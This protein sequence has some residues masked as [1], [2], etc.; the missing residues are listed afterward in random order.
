MQDDSHIAVVAVLPQCDA[1]PVAG[2]GRS[3]R[4]VAVRIELR[5]A[6]GVEAG[7][8][9]VVAQTGED[10]GVIGGADDLHGAAD[11]IGDV[12]RDSIDG[13]SGA[14]PEELDDQ[15]RAGAALQS[16]RAKGVLIDDVVNRAGD[17]MDNVGVIPDGLR[18][19]FLGAN[20]HA[21]HGVARFGVARNQRPAVLIVYGNRVERP[22]AVA[23]IGDD[24]IIQRVG[25]D[26]DDVSLIVQELVV[27]NHWLGAAN[28]NRRPII[29]QKAVAISRCRTAGIVLEQSVG[30]ADIGLLNLNRIKRVKA[31]GNR[32][33][34][35]RV[36]NDCMVDA[37]L[38]VGI[39]EDS[40]PI[41]RG[42]CGRCV[43]AGE[44]RSS[45]TVGIVVNRR[46]NNGIGAR[47]LGDQLRR[48]DVRLNCRTAHLENDTGVDHETSGDPRVPDCRAWIVRIGEE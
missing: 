11:A 28:E 29:P 17:D 36:L 33:R 41:A 13:K 38:A 37:A 46:E 25:I 45:G 8:D 27:D 39:E 42:R 26:A 48:T 44:E 23:P 47:S 18:R 20:F 15:T 34:A 6:V 22:R 43:V 40:A 19:D 4:A 14:G 21:V 32:H 12:E 1:V 16:D 24:V 31:A 2:C 3:G 10:D 9:G 30:N 7:A 5:L 35:A